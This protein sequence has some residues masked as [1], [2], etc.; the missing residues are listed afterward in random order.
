MI[1]SCVLNEDAMGGRRDEARHGRHGA[2]AGEAAT[3][4]ALRINQWR[5]TR[6]SPDS[7]AM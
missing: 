3:G 1:P 2:R 4:W 6:R 7:H 5:E